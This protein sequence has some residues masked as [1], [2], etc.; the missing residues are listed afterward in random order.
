MWSSGPSFGSGRGGAEEALAPSPLDEAE[1]EDIRTLV[2]RAVHGLPPRRRENFVLVRFHSMSF[3][4]AADALDLSPQTVAN[5][6]SRA[7][8][9][10][11]TAPGPLVQLRDQWSDLPFT[12]AANR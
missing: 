11:R 3:Q 4:E 6:M 10:L 9:D 2:R 5:Q 7:T 1:R 8:P 12:R